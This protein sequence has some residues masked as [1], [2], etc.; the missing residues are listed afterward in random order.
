MFFLFCSNLQ[1]CLSLTVLSLICPL[2]ITFANCLKSTCNPYS[3]VLIS[4]KKL[5]FW[6]FLLIIFWHLVSI[7]S[8]CMRDQ[9]SF[10]KKKIISKTYRH[11]FIW[12]QTQFDENIYDQLIQ[13]IYFIVMMQCHGVFDQLCRNFQKTSNTSHKRKES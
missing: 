10:Q 9:T 4:N 11:P 8:D 2:G 13:T 7:A 3:D 1:G 12:I 6:I 5:D